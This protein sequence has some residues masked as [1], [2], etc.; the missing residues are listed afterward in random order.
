MAGERACI[1]SAGRETKQIRRAQRATCTLRMRVASGI[2]CQQE[3]KIG[4]RNRGLLAVREAREIGV[5]RRIGW[6][7]ACLCT[8]AGTGLC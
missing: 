4:E 2:H 3:T 5:S 1:A 7:L 8:D 6:W